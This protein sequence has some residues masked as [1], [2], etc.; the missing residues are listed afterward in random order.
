MKYLIKFIYFLPLFLFPQVENLKETP[1]SILLDSVENQIIY[2]TNRSI[3]WINISNLETIKSLPFSHDTLS[4]LTTLISNKRLNFLENNSGSVYVLNKN[5]SLKRFDNSNIQNFFIKSNNFTKNDTIFKHGGY[6]YWTS[7]NFIIYLDNST[8][9]WEVYPISKSSHVPRGADSHSNILLPNRY[10]FFGGYTVSEH[11]Y[12]SKDML[13]TEIWDFNF[14]NKAWKIL[15]NHAPNQYDGIA[16]SFTIGNQFF[17]LDKKS[18]FFQVDVSENKLIKYKRNPLLYDFYRINPVYYNNNVYYINLNGDLS[19]IPLS[20]LTSAIETKSKFYYNSKLRKQI[21]YTVVF[22]LIFLIVLFIFNRYQKNQR[23]IALLDNGVKYRG[24]YVEMNPLAISIIQ[25]AIKS[26]VEFS[27]LHELVKKPHLS[28]IQN[29]RI[30]NKFINEINIKLKV[31]TGLKDD[32]L[33]VSKSNYDARYKVVRINHR[34]YKNM[35]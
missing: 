15:G 32:F 5:D 21:I 19:R 25:L 20:L 4:S 2:Q 18:Y 29:E 14:D 23:K 10:I 34:R 8:K 12:R 33:I 17:F 27:T 24:K 6:G 3:K 35:I 13:N 22:S 11:R 30:K 16:G 31:L 26:D 1:I 7:S 9:E 28:K